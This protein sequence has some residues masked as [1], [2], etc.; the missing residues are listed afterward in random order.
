MARVGGDVWLAGRG[1]TGGVRLGVESSQPGEGAAELGFPGPMGQMQGQ[2]ASERV[3]RPARE[4]NRRR[5]VLVVTIC[6]PSAGCPACQVV[7][8][9]VPPA[10]R[11]WRRWF[12]PTPYFRSRMHSDSVA[13][14]R[15]RAPP[16]GRREAVSLGGE[17]G[18][19]GTGRGL[20]A[21]RSRTARRRAH[22]G[23]GS[24]PIPPSIQ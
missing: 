15:P 19:L 24:R 16:P 1:S 6:S 4:K 12:S 13:A 17:E 11:R 8:H 23:V 18:Q 9:Y 21:G 5:R 2:P 7:R 20:H 14:V 3:S 22:S 10:R